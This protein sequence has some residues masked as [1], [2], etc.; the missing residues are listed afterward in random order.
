M[1]SSERLTLR[2]ANRNSQLSGADPIEI[3]G[4]GRHDLDVAFHSGGTNSVDT[5]DKQATNELAITLRGGSLTYVS[6]RS[7]ADRAPAGFAERSRIKSGKTARYQAKAKASV[8]KA[9]SNDRQ[10]WQWG[11]FA[12]GDLIERVPVLEECQHGAG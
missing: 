3:D 2:N 10:R 7:T 5:R 1:S 4:V 8:A 12:G 11:T 9:R 6:A